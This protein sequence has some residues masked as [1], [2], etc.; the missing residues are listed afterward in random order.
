MCML[1][2]RVPLVGVK[3]F[4]LGARGLMLQL[5]NMRVINTLDNNLYFLEAKNSLDRTIQYNT[6][7]QGK[8]TSTGITPVECHWL[9]TPVETT[10]I[11]YKTCDD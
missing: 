11:V 2:S 6:R 7:L 8:S 10:T 5:F 3:G 9:V 4:V 1:I